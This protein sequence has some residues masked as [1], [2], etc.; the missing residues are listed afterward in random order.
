M[1]MQLLY[2][3]SHD[4]VMLPDL[5]KFM[6]G[7]RDRNKRAQISSILLSTS[8]C[9]IHLLEGDRDKVN[10]LYT[11]IVKDSRHTDCTLLRYVDVRQ[12]E[13]NDWHAEYVQVDDYNVGDINLLLPNGDIALSTIT[14][15]Q[16]VTMIRRIHAHLQV[17]SDAPM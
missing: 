2:V 14:S 12:R 8:Q 9:Y 5:G 3:S 1:I 13:F 6:C 10:A 11:R 16:A 4:G 15:A 7:V 17:G